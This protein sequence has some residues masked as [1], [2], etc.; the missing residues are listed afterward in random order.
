MVQKTGT[1]PMALRGSTAGSVVSESVSHRHGASEDSQ[2]SAALR[3]ATIRA[4]RRGDE[5]GWPERC[6]MSPDH[7]TATSHGLAAGDVMSLSW[8]RRHWFGGPGEVDA[9][10]PKAAVD[11]QVTR[12]PRR[13]SWR[14]RA[15][16]ARRAAP[17]A[18]GQSRRRWRPQ[19][20][21]AVSGESFVGVCQFRGGGGSPDL[22]ASRR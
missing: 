19:A 1:G 22:P 10:A 12:Q 18:R 20:W 8:R 17:A 16:N 11:V 9:R 4:R 21:F 7:V 15:R 6:H 5:M 2:L 14:A 3:Y 13:M